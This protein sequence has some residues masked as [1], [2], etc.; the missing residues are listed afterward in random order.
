MYRAKLAIRS[1]HG[2][3]ARKYGPFWAVIDNH[4]S[5]LFHHP[6]Y[7]AAY[8]L[9]PSYRYRSDFLV[10]PEVVRGLN[11][12]I[13]RL[14]PDNMRRISASMQISDFNSAKA[15]FG[16]ELAIST[17][18]ELDPGDGN[19]MLNKLNLHCLPVINLYLM[20]AFSSFLAA[21]WQQHG[22]NCLELQRIAVRILS[23]TCS[24]FGCE[25]NWSTYDQIHRE[26][27]N[28]LAQKRLNDLIYVHY[29]LRLRE[30]QL[31]KR[32]NDVMSLDSILLESLLDDWIVEAENPTVQE[33]EE[34]PYNEM[35][36]TDAYENDL[37]EY[38]DGTADGRKASLEMVTLSSVEPLDIV[39]PASAGV[40]TDDDTDLN[41]LGDDLSD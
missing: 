26:S 32:S 18:T 4:W 27:H 38:E 16:T 17:R 3:D 41:F 39:N 1:T 5:S 29:N 20:S 31:S 30:R 15:D 28:R 19:R 11:E 25:H 7:M 37:M 40:A 12:C 10:H 23:Q 9:N 35:D 22:I 2:D 21:W 6:L 13:V 14:E 24:S 34:I 8:F 36:H 33:D